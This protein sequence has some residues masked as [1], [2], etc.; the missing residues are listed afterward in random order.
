MV[1]PEELLAVFADVA[2]QIERG[3]AKSV[4]FKA[5]TSE[6][7]IEHTIS[8]E[9]EEERDAALLAFRKILGQLH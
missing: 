3:E 6:G 5:M 7:E 1:T 2:A 4:T 9:T 8:L